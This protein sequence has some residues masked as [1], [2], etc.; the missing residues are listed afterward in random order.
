MAEP[1]R[2]KGGRP[3]YKPDT[4][5]ETIVER[6]TSWGLTAEAIGDCLGISPPTIRKYYRAA[7]LRGTPSMID[8][9][10]TNM[11]KQACKNDFRSVPAAQ[12]VLRTRGGWTDKPQQHEIMG[13]QGG[14]IQTV[15]ISSK[16][17]QMEG[18]SL[19]ELYDRMIRRPAQDASA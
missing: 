5:T 11:V 13:P 7:I 1:V 4:K 15:N 6:M 17:E 8:K 9:V 18:E 19:A 14:P 3:P 12:F 10:A 2:S 16:I